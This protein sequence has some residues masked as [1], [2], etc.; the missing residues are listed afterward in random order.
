M[1]F[2]QV[3]QNEGDKLVFFGGIVQ[4]NAPFQTLDVFRVA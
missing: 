2:G 1:F 4:K 3:V